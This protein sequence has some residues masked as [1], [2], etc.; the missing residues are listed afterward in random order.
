[1]AL[2]RSAPKQTRFVLLAPT[3]QGDMKLVV[4]FGDLLERGQVSLKGNIVDAKLEALRWR[5]TPNRFVKN[6]EWLYV[7]RLLLYFEGEEVEMEQ[8]YDDVEKSI[9]L[10]ESYI[11]NLLSL[12][13]NF[14][15]AFSGDITAEE[16]DGIDPYE[17]DEAAAAPARG[18]RVDDAARALRRRR[19]PFYKEVEDREKQRLQ[20]ARGGR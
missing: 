11:G 1:M 12:E 20:G 10:N 2:T 8:L 15:A 14:N 6:W 3:I 7:E 18:R 16:L 4:L 17:E 5:V 19:P 13:A 9:Q